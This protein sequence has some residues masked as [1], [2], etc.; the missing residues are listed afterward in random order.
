[1]NGGAG[2]E[3]G[4]IEVKHAGWTQLLLATVR[5]PDGKLIR[6]EI[7]DHGAAVAVLPYHPVRRTAVLVRQFRAPVFYSSK[8]H[9]T[10]E[11][12]AGILQEADPVACARREALEEAGIALRSLDHVAKVWTMPGISTERMDLY[13]ATYDD[14]PRPSEGGV[15]AEDE[16]IAVVET[17]LR[18]LAAMAETGQI[19]DM[20]TLLLLQALRLRHSA[21][22]NA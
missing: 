17:G 4:S 11:C 21:L 20:K 1:M 7:E 13:I 3:I 15:A 6:R 8:Q 14:A 18:E 12:I 16:H 19:A 2:F 10:I 22:F 9:Q 5:L